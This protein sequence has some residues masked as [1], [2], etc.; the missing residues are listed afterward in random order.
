MVRNSEVA[1]GWIAVAL[2][3]LIAALIGVMIVLGLVMTRGFDDDIMTK[4]ALYQW[5]KSIG[6]VILTLVVLRLCWR[7]ANPVPRLPETLK[8]YERGLAHAAHVGLYILMLSIPVSGWL[9]ASASTFPTDVFGWFALPKLITPD[10]AVEETMA[11]VHEVLGWVLLA[12][13]AVH[14]GAALK[15]HFVLK[16]DVL[17]RMLPIAAGHR[18]TGDQ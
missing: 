16:D 15:H 3:W 6:I 8:P 11:E 10:Q 7:L 2:H 12:L 14:V 18:N 5:H 17:R 1:Y 4:V 9:L 13:L